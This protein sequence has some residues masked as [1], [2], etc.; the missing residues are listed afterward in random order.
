MRG[1]FAFL[2]RCVIDQP[3]IF[4]PILLSHYL[5]LRSVL[6]RELFLSFRSLDLLYQHA[7]SILTA[8]HSDRGH[9]FEKILQSAL[10]CLFVPS[11]LQDEFIQTCY[12][13]L[14]DQRI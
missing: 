2:L 7:L 8:M 14:L 1:S 10:K 11:S 4:E 12:E 3:L 6:R 5:G 13:S 9:I